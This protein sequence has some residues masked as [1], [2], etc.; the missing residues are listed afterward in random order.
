MHGS[1]PLEHQ[2]PIGWF[3]TAVKTPTGVVRAL[4]AKII[5]GRSRVEKVVFVPSVNE[6]RPESAV[7]LIAHAASDLCE[8]RCWREATHMA[9]LHQNAM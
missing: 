3:D 9:R 5:W 1:G 4:S 6:T 7:R 2:G 8:K